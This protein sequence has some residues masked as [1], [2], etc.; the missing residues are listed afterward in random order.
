MAQVAFCGPTYS[1]R[2]LNID[3]SRCVNFFPELNPD[4]NAKVPISLVGTPGAFIAANLG[5]APIRLM[6]SFGGYLLMICG[7]GLY[8]GTSP[9]SMVLVGTLSTSSGFV[10][11]ADNGI[12]AQGLGGNQLA[13]VDGV[14]LYIYN[15][16][17]PS[18]VTVQSYTAVQATASLTLSSSA[19]SYVSLTYP[20]SGYKDLPTATVTDAGSG[21]GAVLQVVGGYQ[22]AS[23]SIPSGDNWVYPS[24]ATPAAVV[25]DPTGTGAVLTVNVSTRS[26]GG[27][28]VQNIIVS[29]G[30]SGY[31]NPT[32]TLSYTSYPITPTAT[33]GGTA[34]VAAINVLSGGS[35]YTYPT[36]VFTPKSFTPASISGTGTIATI[37]YNNHGMTTG[38]HITLTGSSTAGYNVASTPVT[39]IDINTFYYASTGT[40]TPTTMPT[41]TRDGSPT[42]PAVALANFSQNITAINVLNGGYGYLAPPVITFSNG[43][44][45]AFVP[46]SISG[47]GSVVT[48]TFANHGLSTGDI[49]TA[50]GSSSAGY[51]D[52]NVAVTIT[53]T[54]TF[55]YPA[56]GSGT[57]TVFPSITVATSGTTIATATVVNTTITAITFTGG[58]GYSATP[59][60]TIAAPQGS[61]PPANPTYVEYLDGYFIVGNA[62]L[63]FYVS[64]LY[65]G[66]LWSGLATAAVSAGND[67]V[68]TCISCMQQ[69]AFIGSKTIEVWADAGVSTL[70]GSPFQRVQGAVMTYGTPAPY[71][72]VKMDNSIVFLGNQGNGEFFGVLQM[73]GY[74]PQKVS[75]P[76]IDYLISKASTL[77]TAY[78]Y[79]RTQEGHN[80]YVLTIPAINSTLVYDT[81][82]QMWHE[83]SWNNGSNYSPGRHIGQSYCVFNSMEYLG[84][85]LDGSIYQLSPYFYT[86][87]GLPI[88]SFRTSPHEIDKDSKSPVFFDCLQL[89]CE[90]GTANYAVTA[91]LANGIVLAYGE[92][93]AGEDAPLTTIPQA[94]LSWSNDSGHTWSSDYPMPLGALGAYGTLVRWRRLGQTRDRVY[95][96]LI[97]DGVKKV[98]MGAYMG[99]AA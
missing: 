36:V 84:S 61:Y 52:V 76:A 82:T 35:G 70:T 24:G 34:A 25:S 18:L 77:S 62:S 11:A 45:S 8:A 91:Y 48:A 99:G 71:S 6:Y 20:G 28:Y 60:I 68:Q 97:A 65:D 50:A 31:T 54:S 69:I 90:T 67:N 40:G 26:G 33:L 80:F 22:I 15:A 79:T 53:S 64:M 41:W 89:D 7:S 46:T 10:M 38:E 66:T 37:V 1:G 57:P 75:T 29:N 42:S 96:V 51:N 72:V 16:L 12:V 5:T 39:V 85:Y 14:N 59:T 49:I 47:T 63:K 43:V 92:V 27:R 87:N 56:T 9:V 13:I 98:I 88:A 23:V 78:A 30:G 83:W 86:D 94:Y 93:Q 4:P 55:T 2:S 32:V 17:S 81:T 74:T 19:I 95:R 21:S 3:A 73:I 58:L 44:A